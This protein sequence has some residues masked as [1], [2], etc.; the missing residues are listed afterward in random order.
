MTTEVETK[1]A[2][3]ADDLP[4][5]EEVKDVEKEEKV[6]KEENEKCKKEEV[7]KEK[8][9]LAPPKPVVYKTDFEKDVVYLYQFSRTPVLPS[10]SPFCLKV[11]SYLRMA[12][13]KYENVDHRMKLLSKKGLLPFVEVN[14][15]QICDSAAIIKSLSSRFEVDLDSS[16]TADQRNCSHA[17][18][19]MIES[20]LYWVCCHWTASSP[21]RARRA[22]HLDLQKML[23]SK[24]PA[25]ILNLGFKL[26]MKAKCKEVRAVGLGRH[27]D[28]EI[29][30]MGREDLKVLSDQ[31]KQQQF[32]FGDEPTLLDV[33]AFAN[34]SQLVFQDK[35]VPCALR[36]F[37]EEQHTNLI[38]HCQRVKDRFFPD[39]DEMCNTLELNTHLPKPPPKE[40]TEQKEEEKTEQKSDK[41]SGD[42]DQKVVEEKS[43]TKPDSSGDKKVEEEKEEEKTETE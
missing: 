42:A 18:Q 24:I 27:S 39:W 14:G 9:P 20:H 16:L 7:K 28:E 23:Q 19:R 10:I 2:A 25:S 12:G 40:E 30:A 5:K 13:I 17:L 32:F 8:K 36:T 6:E 33:V 43:E 1:P 31:L 11:E 29:E 22:Y 21:C 4:V 35:E 38:E 41:D 34:V 3:P 26:R 15:E 37:L